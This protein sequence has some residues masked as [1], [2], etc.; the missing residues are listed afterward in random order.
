MSDETGRKLAAIWRYS[1]DALILADVESQRIIDANPCAEK[2]FGYNIEQLKNLYVKDIHPRDRLPEVLAAFEQGVSSPGVF[3]DLEILR[4]DG[5]RVPVEIWSGTFINDEGRLIGVGSFHN[6][7]ERIQAKY[8]SFQLNWALSAINRAVFAISTAETE[9]EMMRLL[10]EGLTSEVFTLSWIGLADNNSKKS[11]RVAAKAGSALQYLDNLNISWDDTPNGLGPTGVAIR[12][13][14]TQVNNDFQSNPAFAPW[15]EQ[16]EKHNLKGSVA[17][18]LIR[19]NQVIGALMVY[20]SKVDVFTEDVVRLFEDLAKELIVGLDAKRHML[21]YQAE[22][23][24]YLNEKIRY[25]IILEQTI[26]ALSTTIAKRDPYTSEHQRRVSNMSAD[27]ARVL[28]W[29]VERRESVYLGG[30]VHDI[31]KINVPSEIL[32]K[33][34]KLHP[35]ELELVKLHPITGHDI[36]KEIDFPWPLA[37]ITRQHHERLDGSGYPDGLK[38]DQ[39]MHESQVVAVADIFEAILSHRPYRP[40]LGRDVAIAE[41]RRLRGVCLNADIVD[42]AIEVFCGDTNCLSV[43]PILSSR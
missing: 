37:K 35:V 38:G 31:G 26:S 39:I 17:T 43:T 10:C 7:S 11:V 13:R 3:H 29:S 2:L 23:R 12:K 8:G 27:I 21:A 20:S 24:N 25:K 32:N 28:G 9:P 22:A 6:I 42:A 33:P 4:F 14:Q 40:G 34:G 36:L 19:D 1:G 18:P 5:R 41:L 30:L 15:A 16:A